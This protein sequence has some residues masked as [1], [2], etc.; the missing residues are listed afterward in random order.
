MKILVTG[1]LGFIGSNFVRR[2]LT[3]TRD[4]VINLDAKTYAG[5]PE[6]LADLIPNP[7]YRFLRA[8][9]ADPDAVRQAMA[10]AEAVVHFAAETH[11]D[12][13]I[14]DPAAFLRTNVLGTHVLLEEARRRAASIKRFLHIS[15]DEVYG[16]VLKGKSREDAPFRPTSP[17]A[18]SKAAAD[19]LAA[20]Y[21]GT[22]GLPVVVARP[23]NNFGPHQYPEKAVPL[24]IT[25]WIEGKPYPLYGDGRQVR[26]WIYVLDCARA[27][28]LLLRKGKPG[29]AY[30]VGG[31]TLIANRDLVEKMRQAMGVP[32]HLVRRVPDRP[33]HDRRY[34]LDST[35]LRRLGFRPS[36]SFD[37]ALRET[38]AWYDTRPRWW[39]PL[40]ASSDFSAYYQRQYEKRL[41]GAAAR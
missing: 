26:N 16:P 25:N 22:Y 39:K 24:M 23:S 35:A 41:K 20:A 34:A 27:I 28:D 1:G 36:F 6:N 15:T 5:N 31:D 19:H 11:V 29:A 33:G 12:R 10:G 32:Q 14:L 3:E 4:E 2:I 18:A 9:I 37:R 38:V 17:Y 21:H 13:S 40:K 7:R 8:D 30:N